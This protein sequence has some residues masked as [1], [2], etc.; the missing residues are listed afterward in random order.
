MEKVLRVS[1]G[2]AIVKF[3]FGLVTIGFWL[4]RLWVES[5][6]LTMSSSE[7]G[8]EASGMERCCIT[9]L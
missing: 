7:I 1:R 3:S 4:E 6:W 5:R 9:L 8:C 2:F